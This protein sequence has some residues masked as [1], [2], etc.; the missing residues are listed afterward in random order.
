MLA[1]LDE[2]AP[3]K[4]CD[5]LMARG[6]SLL[7]LPPHPSLPAPV[8]SHPDM[9]L[10]FAKD[11]ILCTKEYAK[12]ASRELQTLSDHTNK[13]IV[14][15]EECVSGLYP[16]DILLNCAVVGNTLFCHASHSA[17]AIREDTYDAIHFVRQG[18]A[19]CATLPVSKKALITED[20]SIATVAGSNGFDVLQIDS[21]NVSL[22]GYDTGFFG[23]ATSCSPYENTREIFVCGDIRRH[24]NADEI[25]DFCHRF[26]RDPVSLSE[27]PI[28]DL[29]TV[30]L[31]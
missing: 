10:F 6:Y 17:K 23:G 14:T 5:S 18:Y 12:I 30:F 28:V 3:Q 11:R 27:D 4:I 19:K 8:S 1:I 15:V 24:S 9:L 2:R 21:D 31:I 20:P 29:G 22:P 13:P 26:D 16:Y 25:I 7:T